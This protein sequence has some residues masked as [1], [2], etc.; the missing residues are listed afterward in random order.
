MTRHRQSP[1][2]VVDIN[3]ELSAD[4][5]WA[6]KTGHE[7]GLSDAALAAVTGHAERVRKR[8][9]DPALYIAVVGEFN[10]GKSTFINMLLRD[11]LLPTA[12][13]VTTG[14]ATEIR[15]A[16]HLSVSFTSRGGERVTY[17]VTRQAEDERFLRALRRIS[18]HAVL[19]L[20]ARDAVRTL[21]ADP[22]VCGGIE[23][24]AIGHPAALLGQDVVVVDTPGINATDDLHAEVVERVVAETADLAVVLVPA[25]SPVSRVLT[26]FL[27]GTL[28]RHLD[29]CVFVVTKLDDVD[30]AERA[31]LVRAVGVR[32]QRAGVP[33]PQVYGASG[34]AALD[35]LTAP[36]AQDA[37]T[38]DF[39]RL[40]AALTDMARSDH[41]IAVNMSATHL[42]GGL[43]EAAASSA[44][45][46]RDEIARAHRELDRLEVSDLGRFVASAAAKASGRLVEESRAQRREIDLHASTRGEALATRLAEMLAACKTTEEVAALVRETAA[47]LVREDVEQWCRARQN[48]FGARL[49]GIAD[50]QIAQAGRTFAAEYRRL[51]AIVGRAPQAMIVPAVPA[52]RSSPAVEIDFGNAA[53]GVASSLSTENWAMGGA[54]TAAAVVGTILLPGI[55]TVIGGLIGAVIGAAAGD[56]VTKAKAQV[57]G[58]LCNGARSAVQQAAQALRSALDK[59]RALEEKRCAAAFAGLRRVAASPVSALVAEEACR[60]A[61][62]TEVHARAVQAEREAD[63]R[64]SRLAVRRIELLARR[65][66]SNDR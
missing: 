50:E 65:G 46:R 5:D 56:Q 51:A 25:G 8:L 27:T 4:I 39:L 66:G 59:R 41:V 47:P 11:R 13:V 1:S 55:G 53:A 37:E 57:Q 44:K 36:A 22:Q 19:P 58:P 21:I 2:A 16:A 7:L 30:P 35:R 38:D 40:E 34:N 62:L 32:L 63:E 54:A 20:D 52:E 64:L 12:P 31:L 42:V 28:E 61:K 14:T 10:S 45:E 15:Y 29:R 6:I 33:D 17:P 24:V 18:P 49:S 23:T 3:A 48:A 60:R 9:R 26:T 43:L